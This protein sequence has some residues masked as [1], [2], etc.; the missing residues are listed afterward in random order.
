MICLQKLPG[1]LRNFQIYVE[2]KFLRSLKEPGQVVSTQL[3]VFADASQVAYL[4]HEYQSGDISVR[5]VMS[6]A[7]FTPLQAISIPRLELSA[8]L[9]T[10]S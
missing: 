2:L 1:G 4:R 3:H 10:L 8:F 9:G 7:K 6:K 5:V